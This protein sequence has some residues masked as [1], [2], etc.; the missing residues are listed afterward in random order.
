M[1]RWSV[2]LLPPCVLSILYS[3]KS[4]GAYRKAKEGRGT[5]IASHTIDY[6]VEKLT[7]HYTRRRFTPSTELKSAQF[8]KTTKYTQ[9]TEEEKRNLQC[10]KLWKMQHTSKATRVSY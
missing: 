7:K 6:Q 9:K 4:P 3:K 1:G 5:N 8:V 2:W 10:V